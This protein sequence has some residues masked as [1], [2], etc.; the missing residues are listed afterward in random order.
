MCRPHGVTTSTRCFLHHLRKQGEQRTMRCHFWILL[1]C[2]TLFFSLFVQLALFFSLLLLFWKLSRVLTRYILFLIHTHVPLSIGGFFV[3]T[4][5][6]SRAVMEGKMDNDEHPPPVT[7][8]L[9]GCLSAI[10]VTGLAQDCPSK[11]IHSSTNPSLSLNLLYSPLPIHNKLPFYFQIFDSIYL[12][13]VIC[14]IHSARCM[15]REWSW[16]FLKY[17]YLLSYRET[18][19][20]T[21]TNLL[22]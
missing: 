5:F 1:F 6:H 12:M 19:E 9:A 2:S 7:Y 13:Q 4:G 16:H 15:L 22:I 8:C 11:W 10:K 20:K 17:A 14:I 3:I 18:E 21:D